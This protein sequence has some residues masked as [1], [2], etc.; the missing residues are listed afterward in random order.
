[1]TIVGEIVVKPRSSVHIPRIIMPISRMAK[2][3]D[4]MATWRERWS[5]QRGRVAAYVVGRMAMQGA[6]N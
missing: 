4:V 1:M 5:L 6:L 3:L 2:S